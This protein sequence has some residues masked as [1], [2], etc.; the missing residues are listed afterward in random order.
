MFNAG[1]R[2]P[3]RNRMACPATSSAVSS[4]IVKEVSG[5]RRLAGLDR[6][7]EL[8]VRSYSRKQG[9]SSD[10][11]RPSSPPRTGACG[12]PHAV[13][14]T[15]WKDGQ[16][17]IFR[18]TSGLPDDS[19]Q[20]LFED[21]RGRVWVFTKGGLGVFRRQ[22][23]RRRPRRAQRGGVLHNRETR[24][25]TCGSRANRGLT[26]LRAA[27]IV[28]HFPWSTVGRT[29]RAKV[30]VSTRAGCGCPSGPMAA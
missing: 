6:F 25:V 7:R 15:R 30:V 1:G 20:S 28:E 17:T 12:S 18:R 27:R 10:A 11:S 5:C 24:R 23:V 29:Q 13:G 26:H 22:Q 8:P 4:K 21:P 9:L 16:A 14:L 19:T 3:L 2:T